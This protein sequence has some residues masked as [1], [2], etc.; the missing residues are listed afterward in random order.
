MPEDLPLILEPQSL[1]QQLD[2]PRLLIVDLCKPEVYA[3]THIP[4][5]HHVDY[6]QIVRH[7]KPVMGLLPHADQLSAL[8]STLGLSADRHVVAYDD[9]GGGRA[10]R[11]LWTLEMIGHHHYSLLNGGIHAWAAANLPLTHSPVTATASDYQAVIDGTVGADKNTILAQLDDPNLLLLDCRSADEYNG[12]KKFAAR[13]GH[14]PG[15]INYDWM[16][17]IDQ[18]NALRLKQAAGLRDDLAALGV[19]DDK[20]IIVYCQTHHRSA[21]TYIML[22]SLGFE[23]VK[24]YAGSWSEWGNDSQTPME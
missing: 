21:H 11:L 7:E 4:G 9:E 12:R 19:S 24:G 6:Q 16:N 14:I 10:A 22:K 23:Q 1:Q 2:D 18:H 15:A 3:Q 8:F 17:A 20:Q 13:A 5:A